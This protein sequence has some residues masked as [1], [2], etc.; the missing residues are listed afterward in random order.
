MPGHPRPVPFG[1]RA[2][3]ILLLLYPAADY[4]RRG[5]ISRIAVISRAGSIGLGRCC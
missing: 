3:E 2:F 5:T 4:F 1:V